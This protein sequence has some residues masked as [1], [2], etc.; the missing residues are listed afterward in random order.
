[1]ITVRGGEII[2]MKLFQSWDEALEAIEVQP[3]SE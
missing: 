2:A 1:V 3:A